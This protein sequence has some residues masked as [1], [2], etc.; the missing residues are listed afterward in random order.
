MSVDQTDERTVVTMEAVA[1]RELF[2]R[3]EITE[4][5]KT[6]DLDY[7]LNE[8]LANTLRWS[9]SRMGCSV[10]ARSRT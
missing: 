2:N 9:S 1:P 5:I 4:R 7:E 3:I 8:E 6:E 10:S